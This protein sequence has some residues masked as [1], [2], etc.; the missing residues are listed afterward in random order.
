VAARRG[1]VLKRPSALEHLD[2]CQTVIFDKTGT[3]TYGRPVLTEVLCA[4]GD[5]RAEVL[6]FA[7]SLETYSK[8]PLASAGGERRASGRRDISRGAVAE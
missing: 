8:H 4:P 5:D 6:A 3:L 2:R 1:I 7:A